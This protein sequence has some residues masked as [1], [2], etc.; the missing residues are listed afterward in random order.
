MFDSGNAQLHKAVARNDRARADGTPTS[1]IID[2]R[3]ALHRYP[4][5]VEFDAAVRNAIH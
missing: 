1:E 3:E 4:W 2:P 5:N